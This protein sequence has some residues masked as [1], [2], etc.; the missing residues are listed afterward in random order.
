MTYN[1][2][3]LGLVLGRKPLIA[4]MNKRHVTRYVYVLFHQGERVQ[5]IWL[6]EFVGLERYAFEQLQGE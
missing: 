3:S 6:A 1:Q 5:H 4:M 2:R